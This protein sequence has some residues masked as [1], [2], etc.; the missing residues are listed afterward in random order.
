MGILSSIVF[1]SG[2][3]PGGI[4]GGL[5]VDATI[6]SPLNIAGHQL[7]RQEQLSGFV[8]Q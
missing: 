4:A 1:V 3:F 7:S 2:S 5:K 6:R 8:T